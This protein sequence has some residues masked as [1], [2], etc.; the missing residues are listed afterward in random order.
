MYEEVH[1]RLRGQRLAAGKCPEHG[2]TLVN[3]GPMLENGAEVGT[4]YGCPQTGCSFDLVAR[5]GT[6]L[7]K[8]LR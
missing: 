3:R 5:A 6:R 4:T 1:P 7:T 2:I 8:L